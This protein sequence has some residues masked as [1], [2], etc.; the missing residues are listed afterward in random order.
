MINKTWWDP[1][2][3]AKAAG[4]AAR[5]AG[6]DAAGVAAAAGA[7]AGEQCCFWIILRSKYV[8]VGNLL[9]EKKIML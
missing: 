3:K 1:A 7:A 4:E 9:V 8:V 6:A 5:V 2:E